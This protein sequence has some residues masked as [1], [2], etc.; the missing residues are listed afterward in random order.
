M[1]QKLNMTPQEAVWA[2]FGSG[3][4]IIAIQGSVFC[5]KTFCV[6]LPSVV[7]MIL[8]VLSFMTPRNKALVDKILVEPGE[9]SWTSPELTSRSGYQSHPRYQ[10][11]E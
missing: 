8:G 4:P 9:S 2:D 11:P 5:K 6:D 10:P 7:N 1:V 3:A